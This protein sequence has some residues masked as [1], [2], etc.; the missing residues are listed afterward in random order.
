MS[1][2]FV[3]LH[4]H[5]EYSLVDGLIRIK[6]LVR[7]AVAKKMPAIT[8]TDRHNLFAAIKLYTEAQLVGIKPIIGA[9]LHLYNPYDPKNNMQFLLLCMDIVGYRNISYLLSKAYIEGQHLGIPLLNIDWLKSKTGGLICL[10]GGR[11]GILGEDLLNNNKK[12]TGAVISHWKDLFPERLYLEIIRTGRKNEENYI[13]SAINLAIKYDLPVVAT[14][15]VCFLDSNE[16]EAHEA[17]VSIHEGKLLDD[18]RRIRNY[19]EQQYLRT[20]S[21]MVE[22]FSDIPE[23]IEN[24]IEIAKRCNLKLY[25]GEHLFPNFPVSKGMY[26]SK[27]LTQESYNGLEERLIALF[28]DREVQ[29]K[30]RSQYKIRLQIEL[31]VI[32]EMDFP[33]Y[34]LIVADFIRW[35]KNNEVPVGPG[36]GSSAGSL[37]AYALNITEI[38]PLKY[39]LLF[40]RFLNPERVSLPDFD[41]DFCIEG[42][43]R[44]IEYVS[45]LYGQE[46]VAQIITYGTMTAKAVLRD[47]GRVLGQSY[48]MVDQLAKLVPFEIKMTL[49]KAMEQEPL[50]KDR[51]DKEKDVKT[52]IDL[53]L[54]LE[55]LT[56]NVSK[57]AGGVIIAPKKII[58]YTPIYCEYN[59]SFLISQYDKDDVERMGLVKFDFLGLKTLTII[60]WAVKNIRNILPPTEAD[61]IN[62]NFISLDDNAS[63]SLLQRCQ[64]T[65]IFQLESQ[66][67]KELVKRLQPDTFEDIIALVALFRPGP[68]QSGMVDDFINRKHGRAKVEYLHPDL[69]S[70]L[71]PTYGIIVYQEQVMQIAQILAGYSLGAADML[72]RA[73]GKKD[74]EEMAKQRKIFLKGS[75]NRNV[76][77]KEAELI[78]NLMEKFAEYGFNKSHSSAY[79]LV[80]YQTTWLKANYP[81]AFMAAVLSANMDDIDKIVDLVYESK[82]MKLTILPPDV[83]RSEIKFTADNTSTIRYGLGAIKGVGQTALT[84]IIKERQQGS[85]FDNFYSLICR[86]DIK[87]INKRI[88]K[89]LIKAGA[90]DSLGGHRASLD[91]SL[92]TAMKIAKQYH[93]NRNNGQNDMF[94]SMID[95]QKELLIEA[96]KWSKWQVLIAE[97]EA[98]GL[99]LSG[100]PIDLHAQ[101]LL[102]FIPKKLKEIDISKSSKRDQKGKISIMIAGL[103]IAIR[104]TKAKDGRLMAFIT[105]D[106]HTA[107]LEVRVYPKVYEKFKLYI[108]PNKL[109]IIKG[110]INHNK[111]AGNL[112]ATAEVIYDMTSAREIYGNALIL[113]INNRNGGHKWL[114]YLQFILTPFCEGSTPLKIEYINGNARTLVRLGEHWKIT[115][116]DTLLSELKALPIV[117]TITMTYHPL[118]L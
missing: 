83:N 64:T 118:S 107:H 98:L 108:Q 61:N 79:A 17:K 102:C 33:S 28:P 105:L 32:N 86:I 69:K 36:R 82:N 51:Y 114:K 47:V 50:L 66:G 54:Q 74:P 20:E 97:K 35:A 46:H 104:T 23:A 94:N 109:V 58:E 87:K 45:R 30:K 24:T 16:F 115:P 29:N 49:T 18:P 100:H 67:M 95:T 116:T 106:D 53:A 2:N 88:V 57:H 117:S 31:D 80:S 59:G 99:Y 55:G 96:K 56:K 48:S 89:S 8:I 27:F 65:A 34:F 52:L 9:E 84:S 103:I 85:K 92:T 70:V 101:E 12:D 42:R 113:R 21:E 19:S 63:Y 38:D 41:I 90:M 40:E 15:D 60:D 91:A 76:P 11:N 62:I 68:L 4:L 77:I 43:D 37:V 111:F 112:V 25:L 72:R 81:A 44:V 93:L 6:P 110:K 39:N 78:F 1:C 3:H 14:N 10:T 7:A 5:T 73:M 26:I 75:K 13:N 22:L 71:E